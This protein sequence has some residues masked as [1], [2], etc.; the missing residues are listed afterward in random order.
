M[1]EIKIETD[2]IKLDSF[3]KFTGATTLGSESKFYIQIGDVKVNGEVEIR[4]GKK[5]YP[6]DKVE[7]QE[8]IYIVK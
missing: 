6:G 4:R 3:L 1:V 2:F 5:L 8:E 7:F